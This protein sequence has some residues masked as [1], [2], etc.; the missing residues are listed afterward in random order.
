MNLTVIGAGYV[1][2][3]GAV[4]LAKQG[5]HVLAVEI[6]DNKL[7]LLQQ[8]KSPIYEEGLEPLL[9]EVLGKGNLKLTN[10]LDEAVRFATVIMLC[11]GTPQG[12]D[13]QA[14]LDYIKQAVQQLA[15]YSENNYKLI[16]EKST[17]PINTHQKVMAWAKE[18]NAEANFEVA[19]NPEFLREGKA[20]ADF[21]RPD[22]I[23]CGVASVKAKE[24]LNCLYLPFINQNIPLLFTNVASS[25]LIKQAANSFLALK[26]SYA[27]MLAE[28]CERLGANVND[29]TKGIG[30][31]ERI[32]SKFLQAGIGYGGSCFPKDIAA[33][34]RT[35]EEVGLN[36]G[37]LRETVYINSRQRE[38]FMGKIQTPLHPLNNK[39]IAVWGLAFKADT[40]DVRDAPAIQIV[41]EL[42]GHQASVK[43]YDPKAMAR[44]YEY[45][46]ESNNVNY[47]YNLYEAVKDADALVVLT[48]WQ[49]FLQAD[50]TKVKIC[51]KSPLIFDARN[52]LNDEQLKLAGFNYVSMGR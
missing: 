48:E 41:K 36:L 35:G 13:G 47:C 44:F 31:D 21:M 39:K 5:H 18:V 11:V 16:I 29:V 27:N 34:I 38:R 19:S 8:G 7:N 15:K 52:A 49:E 51:L 32:G 12:D 43:L 26:I 10:N 45:F 17:V 6:D 9:Q 50:F 33:F 28:L 37:L 30:L 24:L 22:R 46:I 3:V 1:G 25:E 20:V 14:N 23:V 4:C 42:L 40:D 2:L